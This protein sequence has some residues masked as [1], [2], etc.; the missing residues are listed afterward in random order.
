MKI[1]AIDSSG[2]VASAAIWEGTDASAVGTILA[3]ASTD[4][5][6]THSQTLLPMID[7]IC[8]DTDSLPGSFDAVAVSSGPGSFTGLRIGSAT[9]KAI[10][11]TADVPIVE[12]PTLEGLAYNFW[13]TACA[14]CPM[15]DARRNQVYSG[16]YGFEDGNLLTYKTQEALALEDMMAFVN[17]LGKEVIFLG[18]GADA[19]HDSISGHASVKHSFAPA[20]LNRQNAASVAVLGARM[21]FEGR[22]VS[23]DEHKPV[24]LRMS[25]AE[26]E[27][28]KNFDLVN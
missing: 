10:A 3:T 2:L 20:H 22:T 1:L 12:V 11:M 26:R 5:K 18:D 19:Y 25:Q 17:D 23:S 4:Y 7:G 16:L 27:G 6:K 9:A 15:M 24:Y 13:G 14:V 21:F 8:R 28:A